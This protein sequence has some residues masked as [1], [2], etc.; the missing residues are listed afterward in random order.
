MLW[1]R[2]LIDIF[3]AVTST[4]FC[5]RFLV[6][7]RAIFLAKRTI[8]N[9]ALVSELGNSTGESHPKID[10][11]NFI[12]WLLAY[13][14]L[15]YNTTLS[16]RKY[17][18]EWRYDFD[19]LSLKTYTIYTPTRVLGHWAH[20]WV[21]SKIWLWTSNLLLVTAPDILLYVIWMLFYVWSSTFN[22]L[23]CIFS[24]VYFLPGWLIGFGKS[25]NYLIN[26]A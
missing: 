16:Y 15:D 8:R 10:W 13:I 26:I 12:T 25:Q 22:M 5:D 7:I 4:N 19:S 3:S 20:D 6:I 14:T 17:I 9:M 1:Y 23:F 21:L 24:F 2:Y 18:S 11:L